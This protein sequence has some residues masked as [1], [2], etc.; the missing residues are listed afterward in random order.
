MFQDRTRLWTSSVR[1][2]GSGT[3]IRWD[4]RKARGQALGLVTVFLRVVHL[5]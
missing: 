5:D 4:L 1:F 3:A 2:C